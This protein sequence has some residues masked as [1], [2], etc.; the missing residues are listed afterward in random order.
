MPLLFLLTHNTSSSLS[1]FLC[2]FLCVSLCMS[3]WLSCLSSLPPLSSL[4]FSFCL[5]PSLP[6]FFPPSSPTQFVLSDDFWEWGLPWNDQHAK[7]H[8]LGKKIKENFSS[9]SINQL[10][11]E[12]WPRV[13]GTSCPTVLHYAEI[14]V[15][16]PLWAH[17]YISPVVTYVL[18]KHCFLELTFNFQIIVFPPAFTWIP[19]PLRDGYN[20]D[21]LHRDEHSKVSLTFCPLVICG[22]CHQL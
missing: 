5:S 14:F 2:V 18:V 17:K 9:P 13:C 11:R 12:P 16:Q 10:P 21:I 3:F 6:P 4:C 1:V 19:E 7:H 8:P 15:N 20:K 22:S